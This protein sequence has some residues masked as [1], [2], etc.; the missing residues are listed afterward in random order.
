MNQAIAR[1]C[2]WTS[3]EKQ[4]G[5]TPDEDRFIGIHPPAPTFPDHTFVNKATIPDYC[6]DLNA[7]HEAEKWLRGTLEQ[8]RNDPVLYC[9]WQVYINLLERNVHA[10]AFTKARAFLATIA[11]DTK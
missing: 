3:I 2:G 4:S 10:E 8:Y 11:Q 7:M 1:A 5:R 6:G 9:R